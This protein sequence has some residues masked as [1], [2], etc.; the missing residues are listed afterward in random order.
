MRLAVI[1]LNPTWRKTQDFGLVR[2]IK[3]TF[4][5]KLGTRWDGFIDTIIR[6]GHGN[7]LYVRQI[8]VDIKS[9]KNICVL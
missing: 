4:F 3:T 5:D 2:N 7:H 9:G 6:R 8:F 1:I